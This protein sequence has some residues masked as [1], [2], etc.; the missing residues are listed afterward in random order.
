[1]RFS[2]KVRAEIENHNL[3]EQDVAIILSVII[4]CSSTDILTGR[5][6]VGEIIA[7]TDVFCDYNAES[8]TTVIKKMYNP[9]WKEHDLWKELLDKLKKNYGFN[10]S[11][12][13][14]SFNIYT[15]STDAD[16][17]LWLLKA[18]GYTLE[19]IAK[20]V[21]SYYSR[22]QMPTGLAKYITQSLESS[23]Q[24]TSTTRIKGLV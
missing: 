19:R 8:N 3:D 4:S 17:T 18:Q 22:T 16:Q 21:S 11:H 15:R 9:V 14:T 5:F 6:Q 20:E 2:N 13:S 10:N 7:V 23:L 1:M 12:P 24:M